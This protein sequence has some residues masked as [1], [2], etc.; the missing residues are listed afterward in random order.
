M[1]SSTP[2][3][4]STEPPA[5][6][7]AGSPVKRPGP[8]SG[9]WRRLRRRPSF[10]VPA[11]F[12]LLVCAM[13]AFPPAFAGWFGHGDP[14]R[15]DLADSGLPPTPG[16]PFGFDIQGCD[17]YSNVVYGARSSVLIALL[18]TAGMLAIAVVL[19]LLAGYFRGW[20]DAL[21]SRVMDVFFGFP[22]LVGMIVILQTLSVHNEVAVAGV[23]VLFGWPVLARVMRGSVLAA[24]S[25]EYVAAARGIGASAPRILLRHVLPNSFGPVAVLAGLNVGLVIASE[26][27]LTFLGVGLQTPAIS[28]GVQLNTA[29]QYF[30]SAPHLL[31]FPSVFLTVTVLSFVLL[32]DA[33]RDAFD[34]RLR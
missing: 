18:A 4:A 24:A 28:W 22:S 17:L 13:A 25:T 26:S 34:P 11:V 19:G 16:H 12:V 32:G 15:C 10:L 21:V 3:S 30:T 33:L 1:A 23:L 2:A 20:V 27:A 6:P 8:G 31:L 29:Q 5:E 7:L 9:P 14:R